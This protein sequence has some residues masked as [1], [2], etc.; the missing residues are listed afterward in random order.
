MRT[1]AQLVLTLGGL[2]TIACGPPHAGIAGNSGASETTGSESTSTEPETGDETGVTSSATFVPEDHPPAPVSCNPF[3]QDCPEGEKCVPHASD[4][5]NWDANKCVPVN[6]DQA[7]GEPC[8]Y[9]GK[10]E[11]TDDCD[12][13][14]LCW[15][16]TAVEGELVG[17]CLP[18]CLG[19]PDRPECPEGSFCPISA[20]P[21]VNVCLPLCDPLVQDCGLG[22]G[23][24][25]SGL[26][27][28]CLV[29]LD[30][31]PAGE[32]CGFINGCAPGLGCFDAEVVPNCAGSA[33]CSPFCD[34]S[35]GDDQCAVVPG[36]SCS[37]FFAEGS[38]P[39]GYENLG[40]CISW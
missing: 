24:Y 1:I 36:T 25:W 4:G 15:N 17:E 30:D 40:V 29:T 10:R 13:S 27:F 37:S 39:P 33:C 32:P 34:L 12:A 19:S 16:V 6:G 20:E 23:C 5:E 7:P 9:A 2:A 21:S 38:H 3:E 14:S 22:R 31:I 35:L 18:F 28:T 26:G 8:S 11:G